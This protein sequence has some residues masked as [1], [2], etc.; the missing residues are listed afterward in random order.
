M[1]LD[2]YSNNGLFETSFFMYAGIV[3]S[4]IILLRESKYKK[5]PKGNTKERKKSKTVLIILCTMLVG[6]FAGFCY[7]YVQLKNQPQH[8]RW[9]DIDKNVP[10][11]S[12]S[13]NNRGE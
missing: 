11:N 7:Y 6:C 12:Q 1:F 2:V 8:K 4:C 10:R 9:E 13:T 3:L 5:I